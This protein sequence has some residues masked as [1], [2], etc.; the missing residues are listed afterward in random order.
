MSACRGCGSFELRRVLD[1]GSVPAADHFPLAS[2]AVDAAESSHPLAM[3]FC[4]ICRLAQLADDDTVTDEP[5]GVEPQALKDQ[6]ADAVE[7]VATSGFLRG[8][9]VTEFGS[10]H[11]GTWL[12]L[13]TA[14]GFFPAQ[15]NSPADVVLDCFGI[16]HEPDQRAAFRRRAEAM[17]PDGVLLLQYHSLATIV[18]D[19]QWNALRHGH[20]GYY[21]LTALVRLLDDAGL[22]AVTAWEFDLYGG[23]V[24]IAAVRDTARAADSSIRSVLERE[25]AAGIDDADGVRSLQTAADTHSNSLRDWL[26]D[27]AAAGERVYAYGAASR[28]V[29]LFSLARLDHTLLTAV[30]DASPSKQ[31]RRMP[32]TDIPIISPD[33]LVAADPDAVL[34]TLPDLIGEVSRRFPELDGRWLIDDPAGPIRG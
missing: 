12:P 24:L 2:G 11:G 14:R 7:R 6:A 33:E 5:R 32:G 29:A 23:T 9:A 1:L 16:M 22:R 4:V 25:Q 17:Q 13:L 31:G 28:A 34:L 10:P 30:A 8:N 27:R 20:F 26:V 15:P 19:G 18:S 21:S 3:D